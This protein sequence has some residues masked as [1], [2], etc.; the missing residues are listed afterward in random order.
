MQAKYTD[1]IVYN[2]WELVSEQ[3]FE[4]C[5]D[6]VGDLDVQTAWVKSQK[7]KVD[8]GI[9]VGIDGAL[10]SKKGISLDGVEVQQEQQHQHDEHEHGHEHYESHQDEIEVLSVVLKA[11]SVEEGKVPG[12]QLDDFEDL[13]LSAPKDEVYRIKGLVASSSPPSDS[14]GEQGSSLHDGTGIYI[15]NWAFSRWT[16]T[17][18]NTSDLSAL[19]G[20]SARLTFMLARY[21]STKWKRKLEEGSLLHL[22]G[23]VKSEL[24]VQKIG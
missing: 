17:Q 12:I 14:S 7:G 8:L 21:E 4:T 18:M 5:Q 20:A 15:L 10:I 16:Y 9:I 13:L 11:E 2:K 6:R 24:S 1:L 3:A 22:E 23:G 19:N